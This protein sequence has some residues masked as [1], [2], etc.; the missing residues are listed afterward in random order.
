MVYRHH[1]LPLDPN[2]LSKY[3]DEMQYD[4]KSENV[5]NR[6]AGFHLQGGGGAGEAPPP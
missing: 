5:F 4:A 2:F 3:L 6:Y 1:H